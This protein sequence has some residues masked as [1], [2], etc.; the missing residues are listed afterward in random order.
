MIDALM[1]LLVVA[2]FI[3]AGA[4]IWACDELSSGSL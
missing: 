3:G 2:A 1:I 4:Y